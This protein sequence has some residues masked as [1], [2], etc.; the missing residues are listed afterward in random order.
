MDTDDDAVDEKVAGDEVAGLPSDQAADEAPVLSVTESSSTEAADEVLGNQA[1][2][3]PGNPV[4]SNSATQQLSNPTTRLVVIKHHALV[5]L[6]HWLNV[7][8]L[9]GMIVSGLSIYWAS[10]VFLHKPDPVTHSRDYLAD[11]GIAI[12]RHIPGA[13][14]DPSWFYNHFGLGV[15]NLAGAL[16]WHWLFVYLFLL[17]GILYLL[18]LILGRGYRALLPRRKMVDEGLAMIRYYAGVVSMRILR[19]PWPHPQITTK[20]NALQRG[21]Y[22]SMPI[23]GAL[24]IASGWAMHKPV[25][26]WWLE[27]MFGSYDGARIVHF[28]VMVYFI[29]FLIPHVILVLVDGW[30]TMRSMIVGW[31]EVRE[32]GVGGRV[33]EI[34]TAAPA[35]T[36]DPL[37][38]TPAAGGVE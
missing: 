36:P 21:A 22:A 18:G 28:I 24:A 17:N 35:P 37:L 10:P 3:Q 33:S 15:F 16:R 14:V 27:R 23:A 29:L 30:D 20:Y 31:S 38:P 9:F 34:A 19:R 12:A 32:P 8:I 7:P 11:V 2:G 5:R 1:T 25:Q 13:K 6:S 4:P 26:L